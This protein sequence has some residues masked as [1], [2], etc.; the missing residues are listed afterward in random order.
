MPNFI[1]TQAVILNNPLIVPIPSH[2]FSDGMGA[3]D[4]II[5]YP[6]F[7]PD[8]KVYAVM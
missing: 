3:V 6:V 1:I 5:Y 8:H 7:L 4:L 2:R